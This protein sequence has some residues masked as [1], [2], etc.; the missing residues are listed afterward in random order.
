MGWI[1][2]AAGLMYSAAM[3]AKLGRV[4]GRCD[5]QVALALLYAV[6]S[7][8]EAIACSP[9]KNFR[10]PTNLELIERADAIIIGRVEDGGPNEN[11]D[12]RNARLVVI[13]SIKGPMLTS[14]TDLIVGSLSSDRYKTTVSD[15]RNI[16]DPNPE[17]FY[18]GCSRQVFD[19]GMIVVA[20]LRKTENG[21]GLDRS[22]FSRT[23]ED[24]PSLNALWVKTIKAYLQIVVLPKK[25]RRKEM[26][27]L[28]GTL[29]GNIDDADSRLISHEL[30][31][32]LRELR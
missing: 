7:S 23:L 12:V 15:P 13:E 19:K 16:A 31:R 20:F 11:F 9:V 21:F 14:N 10:V 28:L 3:L 6:F 2:I 18:G 8:G 17:V 1:S 32:A 30:E 22:L 29:S 27:L 24:V 26:E 5:W 4:N 25:K